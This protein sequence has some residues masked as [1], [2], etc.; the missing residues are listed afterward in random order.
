MSPV[1][2][3][4]L[5]KAV[6]DG[7]L[8]VRQKPRAEPRLIARSK[9]PS[10]FAVATAS[11]MGIG[12][13]V[14]ALWAVDPTIAVLP[15]LLFGG[16][17][18]AVLLEL[19]GTDATARNSI[20]STDPVG[21]RR[22][23]GS[24]PGVLLFTVLYWGP[25]LNAA[26]EAMSRVFGS[27]VAG[28][29]LPVGLGA[30]AVWLWRARGL[31]THA[32]RNGR[33]LLLTGM[34]TPLAV[35]TGLPSAGAGLMALI[36]SGLFIASSALPQERSGAHAGPR[37]AGVIAGLA[38]GGLACV[39][40]LAV[41]W[42]SSDPALVGW[43]LAG[44][45]A[46]VGLGRGAALPVGAGAALVA[47]GLAIGAET[48]GRLPMLAEA[49]LRG[50]TARESLAYL[51]PAAVILLPGV[52]TGVGV[53]AVA[54]GAQMADVALGLA[55]GL[56]LY[57]LL[58][59][60]LGA[61]EA[62]HAFVVVTAL[63]AFPI[64][65]AAAT[66]KGRATALLGPMVA[67]ASVFFPAPQGPDA[68]AFAPWTAYA[69][70]AD[71]NAIERA[72]AASEVV[73]SASSQGAIALA[74]RGDA[75]SR[76]Q[77]GGTRLGWTERE[78]HADRFFGHLPL[79]LLENEPRRLLVLGLGNGHSV[80]ALRRTTAARIDI[81]EPNR[82]WIRVLA[83]HSPLVRG[84]L[85]DPAVQTGVVSALGSRER[86]DAILIDLPA[87]WMFGAGA[88]LSSRRIR[89]VREGL[90]PGGLAVFRI[91]LADVS[92]DDLARA[93]QRIGVGFGTVVA[94]LDPLAA[95]HLLLTAWVEQRRVPV[96]A[97]R[98]GWERPS[99]SEDLVSAGLPELVDVLERALSDRDG[100]VLLAE[101]TAGRDAAG[102][103]VVAGARVRR[104]RSPVALA[105]L[106]QAGR[107]PELLFD[108]D[109]VPLDIAAALRERLE[110]G[111]ETRT[112]YLQLLGFLAEGKSKEA[113]GLA[114]QLSNSS[115]NPARDLRSLVA[116]WLRRGNAQLRSGNYESARSELV[117]AWRFSPKDREVN[118]ALARTYRQLDQLDEAVNHVREILEEAPTDIE[119]TLILAD[120][121]IAQGKLS[122]AVLLLEAAE[123]LHPG[124][125]RL[126]TNLGYLLTQLAVGSDETIRRRLA[127]ARVLFQRAAALAPLL[128]QPRAGLA[129]VFYRL[130]EQTLALREIDR[131]LA[132]EESCHY[133]SS[134][135][136]ILAAS[137]QLPAAEA[138]LQRA[139]LACPESL[140]ALVML[141]AV[142]ADQRKLV[143]AR[144][145][146]ERALAVDPDNAA[147]RANIEAFEANGLLEFDKQLQGP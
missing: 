102:A 109:G 41:P 85:A 42:M 67:T 87:P 106:A 122:D 37:S 11:A 58:P 136:H 77:V 57:R 52:V 2:Y 47:V 22:A 108:F 129:E 45:I 144:Q 113:M 110:A 51:L 86:Y 30:A 83:E 91:T 55:L 126:L 60:L 6:H 17:T 128:S 61:E 112:S 21:T 114:V 99:V 38:V 53:G 71:L 120:I 59:G 145:S 80:D 62:L 49:L 94:W 135:G 36:G 115:A 111:T 103:A 138:E 28:G 29:I 9:F 118:L 140:E 4:S 39:H 68:S 121:R 32:P 88:A 27:A 65:L 63:T 78:I 81:A 34:L 31:P 43:L 116:P 14:G 24:T 137:G 101:H 33:A 8:G 76:A 16:A 133:R 104:G 18:A 44:A 123:P 82:A 74:L 13:T 89:A 143:E 5:G 117:T 139:L 3:R 124:D 96:A 46:G 119:A 125:E 134:R 66:A 79:L 105:S 93:A 95:D 10:D 64:A 92:S 100:L 69:N 20:S 7:I 90:Q 48:P 1:G 147:A 50:S 19:W 54:R 146:W 35:V 12:A 131:A 97:M 15:L 26:T 141:G 72:A 107:S 130:E 56:G 75:A 23:L 142:L 70:G 40:L 84:V 98:A 127:R 73:R 132:L 25:A